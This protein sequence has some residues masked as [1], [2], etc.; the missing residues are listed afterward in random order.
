[1]L[2]RTNSFYF[3]L[4]LLTTWHLFVVVV[5]KLFSTNKED[6]PVSAC[7]CAFLSSFFFPSLDSGDSGILEPHLN[8]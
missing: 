6:I 1:M 2:K 8:Q 5:L 7:T 4:Y 3:K